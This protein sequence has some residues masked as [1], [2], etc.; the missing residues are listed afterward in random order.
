[1]QI[2]TIEQI[3]ELF[4]NSP[5]HEHEKHHKPYKTQ[6]KQYDYNSNIWLRTHAWHKKWYI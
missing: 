6:P 5:I 3:N 4:A 2:G 1:M